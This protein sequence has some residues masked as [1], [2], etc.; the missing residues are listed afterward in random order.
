METRPFPLDTLGTPVPRLPETGSWQT[1][2]SETL[3]LGIP[4]I[5]AQITQLAVGTVSILIV[6]RLGTADLAAIVLGY[7]YFLAIFIFGS[8]FAS[9]VVPMAA[10]T[11]QVGDRQGTARHVRMGL[12]T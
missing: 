11:I 9:A 4:L 6:G 10:R 7:H 3:R 12:W 2:I 5:G 1:H 8:G